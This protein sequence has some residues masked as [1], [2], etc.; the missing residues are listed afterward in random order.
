MKFKMRGGNILLEPIVE[1][2]ESGLTIAEPK[3][4]IHRKCK[5]ISVGPGRTNQEGIIVPHD[6]KIGQIVL[7]ARD[8]KRDV[9][10]AYYIADEAEIRAVIE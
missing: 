6:L 5:I 4:Y 10:D 7:V 3:G 9:D 2:R 8:I 1:A